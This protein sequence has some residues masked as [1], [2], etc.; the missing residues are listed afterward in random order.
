MKLG[1]T[2]M[3]IRTAKEN[4]GENKTRFFMVS[5]IE[6]WFIEVENSLPQTH[7]RKN[8]L[9]HLNVNLLDTINLD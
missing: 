1:H 8:M 7:L 9:V 4:M 5:F 3:R 6:N 2:I